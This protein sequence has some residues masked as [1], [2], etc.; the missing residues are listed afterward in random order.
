MTAPHDTGT[1][2][3]IPRLA[4]Q[5]SRPPVTHVN[6]GRAAEA[7]NTFHDASSMR[8]ARGTKKLISSPLPGSCYEL[9]GIDTGVFWPTNPVVP[10]FDWNGDGVSKN[11]M[12][13][14]VC[15]FLGN[16][17]LPDTGDGQI[18]FVSAPRQEGSPNDWDSVRL[19]L[20]MG[21][22]SA[23]VIVPQIRVV[24]GNRTAEDFDP[25][26]A[27][28]TGVTA[29]M[30]SVDWDDWWWFTVRFQATAGVS[31]KLEVRGSQYRSGAVTTFD[32]EDV[33]AGDISFI[34]DQIRIG[35]RE[36]TRRPYFSMNDRTCHMLLADVRMG[37][38]G[39]MDNP[40]QS[41][42]TWLRNA[43]ATKDSWDMDGS[44][45]EL[46]SNN[47]TP[48]Y[49]IGNQVH[50]SS[51]QV[52][53]SEK[54]LFFDGTGAVWLK[55]AHHLRE[56]PKASSEGGLPGYYLERPEFTLGFWIY[57]HQW[58]NKLYVNNMEDD[59]SR[60][61]LM[62]WT[63]PV[64][65]NFGTPND[66]VAEIRPSEHLRIE[67]VKEPGTPDE[68][69]LD[70]YFGEIDP[71]SLQHPTNDPGGTT[72]TAFPPPV[73]AQGD[74]PSNWNLPIIMPGTTAGA[75]LRIKLGES[76]DA[77]HPL[78]Y[79]WF[80]VAQRKFDSQGSADNE[81]GAYAYRYL[82][83]VL[84][85]TAGPN[86]DGEFFDETVALSPE[87][88]KSPANQSAYSAI[89]IGVIT[90]NPR[91]DVF[92]LSLGAACPGEY[93]DEKGT[94]LG[95]GW[96]S[97]YPEM[98]LQRS[99]G[100]LLGY[101][102]TDGLEGF[103]Y[104]GWM[105]SFFA[106]KKYLLWDDRQ[107]IAKQGAFDNAMRRRFGRDCLMSMAF[108]ESGG[109]IL[110]DVKGRDSAYEDR[111]FRLMTV[112]TVVTT[113]DE[114]EIPEFLASFP[115]P[116]PTWHNEAEI[117]P[118]ETSPVTGIVQRLDETGE[119]EIY[120]T[121]LAGLY[122]YDR[123]A[124]T[125][126]RVLTLPGQGG[127]NPSCFAIDH[128][129]VI[130]VVGNKGRPVIITRTKTI[131]LSGLEPPLYSAPDNLITANF[132]YAGS[133]GITFESKGDADKSNLVGFDVPSGDVMQFA[134]GYWS[135]VLKTRSAMGPVIAVQYEDPASL[136]QTSTTTT[137]Y[138]YR[139]KITGT[140][141]V[142]FGFNAEL[143]THWEIYRSKPNQSELFLEQRIPIADNPPEYYVGWISE[144]LL[145]EEGTTFNAPPP[146][147]VRYIEM[148]GHRMFFVR[149]ENEPRLVFHSVIGDP[150]NVPPTYYT[151]LTKTQ[152][153]ATGAL[154]RRDRMFLA[155]RDYLYEG[156]DALVDMGP[157]GAVQVPV[158]IQPIAK[159]AGLLGHHAAAEDAENGLFLPGNQTVYTT[160]GG[161]FRR[162]TR[163]NDS[164]GSAG[165]SW[166]WPDSWDI[167]RPDEFVAVN[168]ERRSMFMV[169]GPSADDP[170]RRD[171]L[172]VFYEH[173][174]YTDDGR[175]YAIPEVSRIKGLGATYFAEV[176]DQSTGH[177]DV[178]MGTDLGYL[179]KFGEGLSMGVDYD[180][181][182]LIS[183]KVGLVMST[184]STTVLRAEGN[185][186]AHPSDIF[187]SAP[188]QI[189][190][191]QA[192]G[193]L[194]EITFTRVLRVTV[195]SSWI[196]ITTEAVHGAEP[197]DHW[198]VGP[199]PMRWHS[200]QDEFEDGLMEKRVVSADIRFRKDA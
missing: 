57:P 30:S 100:Q 101:R 23:S 156:S 79:E 96:Q 184:S 125:L 11:V 32:Y 99:Q 183:P 137:Y 123:V 171:A 163:E 31:V 73:D 181:L 76:T 71:D 179:L 189:L 190:R 8:R 112:R 105:A 173:V 121:T 104:V 83:N 20:R 7:D 64:C 182:S 124:H 10:A 91:S 135:D 67:L 136:T 53:S 151:T 28:G 80:V 65:H 74:P 115:R 170:N 78:A 191:P 160:E 75:A 107:I 85:T 120:V 84:D 194:L 186:T 175:P 4:G 38:Q 44:G 36:R 9:K 162:V 98:G 110:R 70:F 133:M 161:V 118:L 149:T 143:I 59:S 72:G 97:G 54:S 188:I 154:T 113:Y 45:S 18:F 46:T 81:I 62:C 129:D 77:T 111:E 69:F 21:P 5:E 12:C 94:D 140:L 119:E 49:L 196:D 88:T 61:C 39:T 197:G 128:N 27:S 47:G 29:A 92:A 174:A 42:G 26:D 132:S 48:G 164:I 63:T 90:L 41:D 155:S 14:F 52:G 145:G 146:E 114:N 187:Q 127:P 106:V 177:K 141:P 144:F 169:C 2:I 150:T 87:G 68:F 172:L 176:I 152:L 131:G 13:G 15:K 43:D 34:F 55:E 139:V 178:W 35:G 51:I 93:G 195:A 147:G 200:G 66:A 109:T 130:H 165:E 166:T 102:A 153:P 193:T 142:P 40:I 95:R 16:G 157:S 167:S 24:W 185:Y 19:C 86:S 138:R 103:A 60:S 56:P 180:W 134:I 33:E 89:Q 108:D 192:D 198:V 148:M 117:F 126:T 58:K 158:S 22:N 168:D 122:E 50:R 6:R 116:S 3:D 82:N 159:N 17:A 199:I 25:T 1:P 37:I